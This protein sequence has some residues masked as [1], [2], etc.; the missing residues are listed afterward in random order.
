MEPYSVYPSQIT[1]VGLFSTPCSRKEEVQDFSYGED[2]WANHS[3]MPERTTALN[4]QQMTIAHQKGQEL[5]SLPKNSIHP[6]KFDKLDFN[7]KEVNQV[8]KSSCRLNS[9]I[10]ASKKP[11]RRI[12]LPK[13]S[14]E[15]E[16][17]VRYC[18]GF[19]PSEA[20]S[21][22]F[23]SP[24][25]LDSSFRDF[26]RK[27]PKEK[28][29]FDKKISVVK[30]MEDPTEM[31]VEMSYKSEMDEITRLLESAAIQNDFMN[32]LDNVYGE[33]KEPKSNGLFFD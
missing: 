16:E 21:P 22:T 19:N 20:L 7:P 13:V 18:V 26:R 12:P 8:K 33:G 31:D 1:G 17:G 11:Q 3:S 25:P 29:P 15:T 5:L 27:K 30:P 6:I 9:S 4:K 23:L 24:Q 32:A 2:S 10:S 14:I 28:S